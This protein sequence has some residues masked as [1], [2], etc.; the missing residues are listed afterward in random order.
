M[1]IDHAC[2]AVA[3][4]GARQ[5]SGVLLGRAV[6]TCSHVIGDNLRAPVEV[7]HPNHRGTRRYS[8]VWRSRA[9]DAALL[10]RDGSEQRAWHHDARPG[11]PDTPSPLPGCEIV[12]RL[13]PART[14]GGAVR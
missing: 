11:S 7:A 12:G 10:T 8:V 14:E 9:L 1:S 6:L 4:L 2:A 13:G 3:V 5:G